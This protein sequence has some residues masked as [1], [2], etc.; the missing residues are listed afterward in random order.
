MAQLTGRNRNMQCIYIAEIPSCFW[1]Y[2]KEKKEKIKALWEISC[3]E[4]EDPLLETRMEYVL[5]G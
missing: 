3:H 5:M 4:E 2:F 1:A